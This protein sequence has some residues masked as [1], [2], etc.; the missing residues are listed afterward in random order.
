M[1]AHPE[2]ITWM[3]AILFFDALSTLAFARLR[4]E[5]RPKKFAFVRLSS[6]VINL[7]SVIIFL[8]VIPSY[9]Y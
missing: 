5:N 1:E 6:V 2:F 7:S 9:V 8:G 3:I 4:Q